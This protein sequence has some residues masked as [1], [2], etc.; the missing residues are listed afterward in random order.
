MSDKI[1]TAAELIASV[2]KVASENFD[3]NYQREYGTDARCQYVDPDTLE[4]RCLIGKGAIEAGI[5]PKV[6]LDFN[7]SGVRRH[8]T[9][10]LEEADSNS[11]DWLA[12]AQNRQ[13]QGVDWGVAVQMADKEFLK[14]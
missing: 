7:R 11:T 9:D 13:D 1:A 2:R 4:G 12:F 3:F 6:F 14:L 8:I 10:I 5:D